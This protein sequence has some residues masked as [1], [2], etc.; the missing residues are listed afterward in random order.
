MSL[1]FVGQLSVGDTLPG[2][3]I[4][5]QIATADAQAR[6]DA[7]LS[8]KASVSLDLTAQI[9]LAEK[10]L[11]SLQAALVLGL[12]APSIGVQIQAVADLTIA[13][14][15]QLRLILDLLK[16]F[17]AQGVWVWH[18]NGRADQLGAAMTTALA[19]GLPAGGGPAEVIDALVL[20][21]NVI[22]TWDAM[23]AIFKVNP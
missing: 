6:L 4:A 18:Y 19:T 17:G 13:L 9:E 7:L 22:T 2:V 11:A 8:F 14:Q 21:T 20:A 10:I 16:L 3:L 12:K 1:T 23:S 5:L 15:L